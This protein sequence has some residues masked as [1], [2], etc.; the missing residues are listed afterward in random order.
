MYRTNQIFFL[1]ALTVLMLP[2]PLAAQASRA[3]LEAEDVP[4]SADANNSSV[5]PNVNNSSFNPTYNPQINLSIS[6]G[7]SGGLNV[8]HSEYIPPYNSTAAFAVG[9]ETLNPFAPNGHQFQGRLRKASSA[10]TAASTWTSLPR[11][12][13][14]LQEPA[15][16]QPSESPFKSLGQEAHSI[17]GVQPNFGTQSNL[18]GQN[19]SAA[20]RSPGSSPPP[21]SKELATASASPQSPG[22]LSIAQMSLLQNLGG[23]RGESTQHTGGSGSALAR[24]SA[25][26][27][28]RSTGHSESVNSASQ[29]SGY[30]SSAG[31]TRSANRFS[32]QTSS[33][34]GNT[35]RTTASRGLLHAAP[36]KENSGRAHSASGFS[37]SGTS[38]GA[39]SRQTSSSNNGAV[40]LGAKKKGLFS[41]SISGSR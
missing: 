20:P 40:L 4:A 15:T 12:P 41:D 7:A 10:A 8:V 21:R 23:L 6:G 36:A 2:L 39:G 27:F 1:I 9:G 34:S 11:P 37:R 33:V 14:G 19:N 32:G 22:Q 13:A 16:S 25:S 3:Q 24:I 5:Q 17:T 18:T 26:G 38:T 29:S 31:N 35:G 28:S 30:N